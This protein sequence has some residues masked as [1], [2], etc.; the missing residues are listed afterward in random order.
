M[1][2]KFIKNNTNFE[3]VKLIQVYQNEK[4]DGFFMAKIRKNE[5]KV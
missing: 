2:Y 5:M 4:A 1:I 3:I